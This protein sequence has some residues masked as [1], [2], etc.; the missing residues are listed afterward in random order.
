MS[1]D[2]ARTRATLIVSYDKLSRILIAG[3]C[4]CTF[5]G[6]A[7]P[8]RAGARPYRVQ[9]RVA[10]CDMGDRWPARPIAINRQIPGS[11]VT[12]IQAARQK[13][14]AVSPLSPLT[15]H[16]S[17]FT[18]FRVSSRAPFLRQS[19]VV[20]ETQFLIGLRVLCGLLC[21][22]LPWVP[23]DEGFPEAMPVS[24]ERRDR[25]NIA[26]ARFLD[27]PRRIAQ[28]RVQCR[29]ARCDM[30]DRWPA[31]PIAINRQI[32]GSLVTVIQQRGRSSTRRRRFHLSP[33]TSHLSPPFASLHGPHSLGKA[34]L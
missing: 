32:P 5:F 3:H 29:V 15:F 33:F 14:D 28:E 31:R 18:P 12:V 2:T 11:L 1:L 13:L 34:E 17:P 30:G 10:R 24:R 4:R 26:V 9:C 16:F 25:S 20:T 23:V 22:L 7:T 6:H 21:N 27:M 8:D 19:R